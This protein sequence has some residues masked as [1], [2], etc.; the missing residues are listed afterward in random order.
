[1][2]IVIT[3]ATV[4][5]ADAYFLTRLNSEAWTNGDEDGKKAALVTA[6]NLLNA[7]EWEGRPYYSAAAFPRYLDGRTLS[8]PTMVLWALYEQAIH[9][10]VNPG[11]LQEDETVQT[12]VVGPIH[13][14]NL[15]VVALIPKIVMRY[16]GPYTRSS[17]ILTGAGSWWRAN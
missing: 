12:L 15:G 13:L 8:T 6:A 16:I 11:V 14:E 7:M 3:D 10:L 5:D 17:G 1:M 9:L 4:D 2:A